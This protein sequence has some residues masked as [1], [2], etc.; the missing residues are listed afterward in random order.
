M[1]DLK[2]AL[3]RIEKATDLDAAKAI[4]SGAIQAHDE[5]QARDFATLPPDHGTH[6][7]GDDALRVSRFFREHRVNELRK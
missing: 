4:A 5:Q 2:A 3:V 1:T 6:R 7:N